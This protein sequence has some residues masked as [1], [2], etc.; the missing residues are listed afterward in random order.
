MLLDLYSGT[1]TIALSLAARFR[2]VFG[3]DSE[4]GAVRDARVNATH[5]NI[6]NAHFLAADLATPE[7]VAA[8]A[9]RVP[10]PNAVIAG[11]PEPLLATKAENG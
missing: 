10:R 3:A 4:E 6:E 7:G 5:N 8:V 2:L 9:A 11:A 1:G